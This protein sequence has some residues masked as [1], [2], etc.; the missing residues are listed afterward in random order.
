MDSAT[1]EAL[2]TETADVHTLK[3]GS[4][5]LQVFVSIGG[6]SFSDS[7]TATQP[8]FSNIASNAANRE[9][10]ANNLVGFMKRESNGQSSVAL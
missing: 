3:S 9:T 7:D 8:V 1:P 2:F 6:W 4:E 5:N 10:F